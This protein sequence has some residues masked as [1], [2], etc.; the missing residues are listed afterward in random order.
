MRPVYPRC[1]SQGPTTKGPYGQRQKLTKPKLTPSGYWNEDPRSRWFDWSNVGPALIDG[2]ETTC[3][4]DN[5]SRV[6]LITPEFVKKRNLDVGSIQ[7]LHHHKGRIPL[8]G[9]GVILASP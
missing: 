5:G 9:M 6:N 3:L 4:L 7:D 1:R 8:G 2:V